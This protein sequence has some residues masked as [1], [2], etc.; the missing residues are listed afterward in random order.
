MTEELYWA[1]IKTNISNA[2]FASE[3]DDHNFVNWVNDRLNEN[4]WVVNTMSFDCPIEGI[5]SITAIVLELTDEHILDTEIQVDSEY[6]YDTLR[7]MDDLYAYIEGTVVPQIIDAFNNNCQI[8]FPTTKS[9]DF[10][11]MHFDGE[12]FYTKVYFS[13][14][15]NSYM[16]VAIQESSLYLI[17][18]FELQA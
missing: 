15:N 1:E 18:D 6:D 5:N 3:D 7:N 17:P 8:G 11:W 16:N 14:S 12:N 9:D 10:K 4:E 13:D 2:F